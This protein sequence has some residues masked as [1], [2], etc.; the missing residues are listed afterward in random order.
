L[1]HPKLVFLVIVLKVSCPRLYRT[2]DK[3]LIWDV[4]LRLFLNLK[5][6]SPSIVCYL[7][8]SSNF[9]I[10]NRYKPGL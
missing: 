5:T 2:E 10:S 3:I 4:I 7:S 1:N 9:G 8:L 6:K